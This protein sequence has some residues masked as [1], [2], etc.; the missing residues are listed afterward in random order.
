MNATAHARGVWRRALIAWEILPT[1]AGALPLCLPSL[2]P[3]PGLEQY[4]STARILR[5]SL[6]LAA[7]FS[8][9][10]C[11]DQA[12][13]TPPTTPVVEVSQARLSKF[14]GRQFRYAVYAQQKGETT[15]RLIN[16]ERIQLEFRAADG[17]LHFRKQGQSNV[18]SEMAARPDTFTTQYPTM[19]DEEQETAMEGLWNTVGGGT[20]TPRTDVASNEIGLNAY[21][22]PD[23]LPA[24]Y[25][26]FQ[27][28]N[29]GLIDGAIVESGNGMTSYAQLH[30]DQGELTG[31]TV[32]VILDSTAYIVEVSPWEL[33]METVATE[34][35]AALAVGQSLDPSCGEA[36]GRAV[37]KGVAIAA[38]VA[39]AGAAL[40]YASTVVPA[41]VVVRAGLTI[42]APSYRQLGK[43]SWAII[44]G[45]VTTLADQAFDM[46]DRIQAARDAC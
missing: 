43:G 32:T 3:S 20:P 46:Y 4:V 18:S 28:A 26:G 33:G 22:M 31:T 24:G 11:A 30:Y 17:R 6:V 12:L 40:Y 45:A 14:H 15:R 7:T 25:A 8:V 42:V 29:T 9:A 27:V 13:P 5:L 38:G 2:V 1:Q 35:G 44:T 36:V 23:S 39:V 21:A 19:W 10:G 37:T 41:A 16:A 34:A